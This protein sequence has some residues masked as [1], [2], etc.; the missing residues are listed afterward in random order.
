MTKLREMAKEQISNRL[1]EIADGNC[2]AS[3]LLAEAL[4]THSKKIPK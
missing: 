1:K 3:D 2:L 4:K